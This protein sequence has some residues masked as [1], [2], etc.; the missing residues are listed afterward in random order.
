[1]F[2]FFKSSKWYQIAQKIT[3]SI[4][5]KWVKALETIR[6]VPKQNFPK[7]YNFLNTH[8]EVRNVSFS[9][10]FAYVLNKWSLGE[11]EFYSY[12]KLFQANI[13]TLYS[14]KTPENLWF[15]GV[16]SG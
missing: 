11:F 6:L 16:F 1:M 2:T 8:Q 4:G 13:S 14:L 9:G 10:N 12:I 3:K 5:L 7:N 15:S